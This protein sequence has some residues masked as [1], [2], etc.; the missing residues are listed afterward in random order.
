MRAQHL[1]RHRQ[2]IGAAAG[3]TPH[4]QKRQRAAP[5]D[6]RKQCRQQRIAAVA[7]LVCKD[8]ILKKGTPQHTDDGFSQKGAPHKAEAK[9]NQRHIQHQRCDADGEPPQIVAQQG[10]T[11]QPAG[12]KVRA[13]GKI[14]DAQGIQKPC[15][16]IIQLIRYKGLRFFFYHRTLPLSENEEPPLWENA[17]RFVF[18]QSVS[19]FEVHGRCRHFPRCL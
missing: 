13:L 6:T 2:E 8:N 5:C 11:R 19:I 14:A 4:I 1:D 9:Q 16:Q 18:T 12:C 17:P 15:D 3:R 7:G 10:Q